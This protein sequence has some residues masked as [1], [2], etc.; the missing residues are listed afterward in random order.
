MADVTEVKGIGRQFADALADMGIFTAEDVAS[1]DPALLATVKGISPR[2][3]M[4]LIERAK[5]SVAA[6]AE[7]AA[8]AKADSPK[9]EKKSGKKE[10]KKDAKKSEKKGKKKKGK[11]KKKK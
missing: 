11:K 9:K 4:I 3:A 7:A 5:E 8:S 6:A 10:K 2:T 1:V